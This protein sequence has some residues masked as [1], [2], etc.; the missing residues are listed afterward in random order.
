MYIFN[1][2]L[3]FRN[4]HNVQIKFGHNC[5]RVE[6][7]VLKSL[8]DILALVIFIEPLQRLLDVFAAQVFQEILNFVRAVEILQLSLVEDGQNF[9]NQPH[10]RRHW[11]RLLGWRV[12][13]V[14][15]LL[16]M[17]VGQ[18]IQ[19]HVVGNIYV[20]HPPPH[21]LDVGKL[22]QLAYVLLEN[23]RSQVLHRLPQIRVIFLPSP[24]DF[25][26][27]VHRQKS[28]QGFIIA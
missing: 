1:T 13:S 17:H 27:L 11:N 21:V 28:V 22:V 9:V 26:S 19:E 14:L 4:F 23:W 25:L 20:L 12:I 8:Q 6:S 24:D 15:L 7:V 10:H 16:P 2:N 18:K 5:T 3:F